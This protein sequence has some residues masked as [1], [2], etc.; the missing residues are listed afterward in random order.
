M[1]EKL[2]T[3]IKNDLI[4]YDEN[5]KLYFNNTEDLEK[6]FNELK[7]SSYFYQINFD[8]NE[9]CPKISSLDLVKKDNKELNE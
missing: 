6:K 1:R 4:I 7:I 9:V 8:K 2:K 3:D 5:Q